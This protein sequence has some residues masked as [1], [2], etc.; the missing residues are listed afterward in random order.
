MAM[1][2]CRRCVDYCGADVETIADFR[3]DGYGDAVVPKD[4]SVGY[5]GADAQT[6]ADFRRGEV[7]G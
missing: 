1:A 3:G 5:C 4:T 2:C 6:I 7:E